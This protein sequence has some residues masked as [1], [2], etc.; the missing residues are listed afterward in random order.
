[1]IRPSLVNED[2]IN[3]GAPVSW[4]ESRLGSLRAA[5]AHRIS[6]VAWAVGLASFYPVLFYSGFFV[7]K[8]A[9]CQQAEWASEGAWTASSSVRTWWARPWSRRSSRQHSAMC[10]APASDWTARWA[11]PPF[12]LFGGPLLRDPSSQH[13]TSSPASVA[14]WM[15][16]SFLGCSRKGSESAD[17]NSSSV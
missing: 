6:L 2:L 3:Q 8:W 13:G 11:L 9:V 16:T 5:A 17:N 10:A 12:P 14:H 15:G 7:Q 4:V 1:M